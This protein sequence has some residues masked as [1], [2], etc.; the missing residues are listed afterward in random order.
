MK[1]FLIAVVL[2][3][4]LG[5]ALGAAAVAGPLHDAARQGDL[6]AL[7]RLIIEGADTATQDEHGFKAL[8]LAAQ[9]G[10]RDIVEFLTRQATPD[11]P[12]PLPAP[13]EAAV[14]AEPK[15]LTGPPAA[16]QFT[17]DD[18]GPAA[19]LATIE[20]AAGTDGDHWVQMASLGAG[21]EAAEI[22]IARLRR[23][24]P[25]LLSGLDFKV[26]RAIVNSDFVVYRIRAGPL[27]EAEARSLC[28]EF[29]SLS[30]DC[31]VVAR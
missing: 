10:H 4:V 20:P 27:E 22:E 12:A 30:Q 11:R 13:V 23:R 17:G 3:I 2:M 31:L 25:V 28:A 21:R 18:K 5:A 6:E 8:D 29:K 14:A 7:R 19:A 26:E 1:R 24:F 9:Y 16:T 15:A